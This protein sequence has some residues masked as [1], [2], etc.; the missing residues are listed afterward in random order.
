[1]K[2]PDEENR[3]AH[4]F[5]QSHL[6][7]T[8][9]AFSKA[10]PA[11]DEK[12]YVQLYPKLKP[13]PMKTRVRFL[14]D[15]MKSRLPESYPKALALLMKA[16][17][18]EKLSGFD[19]WPTTEFIQT[20]GLEHSAISLEA[21][22]I[23][24]TLFTSEWAVRPFIAKDPKATLEFLGQC[25]LDDDESVR[26]WASEGSRPRL[27]WGERLNNLIKDPTPTFAIL[28][29][30]KFDDAL[31]VRKS[32]ANHINDISKDHPAAA[33]ALLKRWKQEAQGNDG[34][35]EKVRWITRHALRTLIKN[36][37]ADALG[38]L[39]A[40]SRPKIAI[41]N[42]QLKAASIKLGG[43][44]EF[45]FQLVSKASVD[46][47]L[48]IDYKL[49]FPKSKGSLSTKVF[50]LKSLNLHAGES[51]QITKS[52]SFKEI[53]TREYYNGEHHLE[54]QIN[55]KVVTQFKFTLKGAKSTKALAAEMK[56]LRLP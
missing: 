45:S 14:R 1:M 33:I 31:F 50:K 20:Y 29:A 47:S 41:K 37:N 9:R 8:G 35:R 32:V 13:L 40:T 18:T 28:N 21:L 53:T 16:I 4:M 5:D 22:V 55:G 54:I 27:P 3:L 23:I 10:Y 51:I 12:S 49:H 46:Q 43:V 34:E 25:A 56:S 7:R 26:R 11:F 39:G 30:L 52:H 6:K 24:T 19:L 36:G 38:L 15:E 42:P 48:V 44:V 2:K 17:K